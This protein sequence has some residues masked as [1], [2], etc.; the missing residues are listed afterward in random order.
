LQIF[1]DLNSCRLLL[2]FCKIKSTIVKVK[3][4]ALLVE[5]KRK[6]SWPYWEAFI[7]ATKHKR[8]ESMENDKIGKEWIYFLLCPCK[9]ITN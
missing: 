6:N 9:S 4:L 7:L 5:K 1:K 2:A 8:I 3:I